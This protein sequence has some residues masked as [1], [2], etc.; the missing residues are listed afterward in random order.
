MNLSD[1]QAHAQKVV[2]SSREQT[3]PNISPD[4]TQIAF[5]SNRSGN[6]EIWVFGSDGANAVQ[7]SAFGTNL[8]GTPRW[9]P[10]GRLIAFDSRVGGDSN[11]YLVEPHGGLPRK[12][13]ID[14]RGNSMPSWSHDGN[15]IYF[16]N[17]DDSGNPTIW[18][19]ASQGGHAMQVT[20]HARYMPLE[21]PDRR[22][23]YFSHAGQLWR[24]ETDGIGERQIQGISPARDDG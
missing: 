17:G 11:I 24:V 22:Y 2:A 23:V 21:S 19:V 8:T 5:M 9:S 3:G 20:K 14:I 18:K 12:L 16:V 6:T 7:L 1:P 13:D 10:D 15:W 4:G